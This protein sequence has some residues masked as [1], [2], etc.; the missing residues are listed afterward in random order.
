MTNEYNVHINNWP[1]AP[2]RLEHSFSP[3]EDIP[4]SISFGDTPAKAI[5]S[6]LGEDQV[7]VIMDTTLKVFETLPVC[8]CLNEPIC[9]ESKY[10]ISISIFDHPIVTINIRGNTMLF[11]I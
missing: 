9:A 1:R 8:V 11:G 6:S 2:V 7:A 4:V 3:E 10:T 5:I